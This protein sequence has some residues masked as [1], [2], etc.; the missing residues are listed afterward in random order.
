MEGLDLICL[1]CGGGWVRRTEVW[2][3]G[4]EV[5]LCFDCLL[6]FGVLRSA[7]GS[8]TDLVGRRIR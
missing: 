5:F 2:P 8:F 7:E 6:P 4:V 3:N 1:F